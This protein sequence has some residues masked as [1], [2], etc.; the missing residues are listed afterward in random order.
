MKGKTLKKTMTALVLAFTLASCGGSADEDTNASA[1]LNPAFRQTTAPTPMP[2]PTKFPLP[3]AQPSGM[4]NPQAPP[5]VAA[6]IARQERCAH[7]RNEQTAGAVRPE[8][9]EGVA[10]ECG[11][12]TEELEALRRT[13]DQDGQASALLRP[14]G[15]TGG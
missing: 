8:V 15:R 14:Y 5:D 3:E 4:V 7:W 2:S 10:R 13:H 9:A 6:H 11:G 1:P 12:I